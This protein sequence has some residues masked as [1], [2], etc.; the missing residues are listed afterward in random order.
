MITWITGNSGAGKTTLAKKM[1]WE[2]VKPIVI[3]DGDELRKV[4]TD[5]DLSEQSRRTQNLRAARLALMISSQGM[6]VIV[7]TICP[8]KDL[9]DQ[10]QKITDCKFI[11]LTG[12]KTG[13][14]YPYEK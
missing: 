7:S 5:L 6:D 2:S 4:W 10:V 12:G 3:L 9:R 1:Q 8:Y 14:E 11:Y 13:E